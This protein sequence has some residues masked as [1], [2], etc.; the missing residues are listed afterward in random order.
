[1]RLFS[2]SDKRSSGRMTSSTK[3][4]S[5]SFFTTLFVFTTLLAFF[6]SSS[7][8]LFVDA[9]VSPGFCGD[10]QTF[11]NAIQPC[12]VTFGNTDIEINGTYSPV[13]AAK[14]ICSDVMQRVLW[15][16]AKCEFLAGFNSHSPPPQAYHTT[17]IGWGQSIQDWNAPYTGVVAPG[18]T[19][20]PLTSTSNPS[21]NPPVNPG[22]TAG[23]NPTGPVGPGTSSVSAGPANPST[24]SNASLETKP[25]RIPA[26]LRAPRGQRSVSRS[27]SSVW[28]W[29]RVCLRSR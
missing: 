5:S 21:T 22:T 12:G 23:A 10:C 19:T 15:T 26:A 27:V 7:N 1:M 16:C 6:S 2:F 25:R 14:C 4:T 18:T 17:C 28:P 24:S 8:N 3:S 13:A 9:G 11:A 20:T 29:S